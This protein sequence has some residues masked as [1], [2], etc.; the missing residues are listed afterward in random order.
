MEYFSLMQFAKAASTPLREIQAQTILPIAL[1]G[2]V[3]QFEAHAFLGPNDGE[4]ALIL[5]RRTAEDVSRAEPIVSIHSR[6]LTGD[7]FQSRRCACGEKLK[8]ALTSIARANFGI[9]IYLVAPQRRSAP[10]LPALVTRPTAAGYCAESPANY[11]FAAHILQSLGIQQ[12]RLV[13]IQ[14]LHCDAFRALGLSI[15]F[16]P[17]NCQRSANC[18]GA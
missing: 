18:P 9:L 13:G 16:D 1:D 8:A 15:A 7:I 14:P 10:S 2:D 12:M 3:V 5:L 17:V 11:E 4:E 6:C